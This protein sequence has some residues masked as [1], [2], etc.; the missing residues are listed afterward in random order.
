MINISIEA[1]DAINQKY[2]QENKEVNVRVQ[3]N[4]IG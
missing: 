4:G 3:I 1:I 2:Y